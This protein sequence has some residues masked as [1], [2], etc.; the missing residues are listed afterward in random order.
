MIIE[1]G[2]RMTAKLVGEWKVAFE[3]HL[4]ELVGSRAFEAD[5]RTMF[6]TLAWIDELMSMKNLSDGAGRGQDLKRSRQD[7]AEFAG[8]PIRMFGARPDDR[9]FDRGVRAARR[10]VRP[11]GTILK[12][13]LA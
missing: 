9:V 13:S 4:P 12:R 7:T 1:N 8:S 11:L 2:E 6:E 3:V 5:E 10:R